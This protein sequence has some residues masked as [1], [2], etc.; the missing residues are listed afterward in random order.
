M[1]GIDACSPSERREIVMN[2]WL[3]CTFRMICLFG[4]LFL[5]N[6]STAGWA[7]D[8]RVEDKNIDNA[9]ITLKGD[10]MISVTGDKTAVS[11]FLKSINSGDTLSLKEPITDNKV[12]LAQV[13]VKLEPVSAEGII[14]AVVVATAV[15]F[16]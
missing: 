15:T 8:A 16:I 14:L 9:T 2:Q 13:Q 11:T 7:K 4:F 10:G 12:P 1:P 5:F 6:F 3:T